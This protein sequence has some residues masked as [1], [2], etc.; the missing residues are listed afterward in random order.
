MRADVCG[1]VAGVRARPEDGREAGLLKHG[2]VIVGNDAAAEEECVRGR[3]PA[4]AAGVH[5]AR[6]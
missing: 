4:L 6:E 5:D 1:D 2:G 3:N